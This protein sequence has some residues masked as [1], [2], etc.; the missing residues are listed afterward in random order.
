MNLR[1]D[2]KEI[3]IV[4]SN[5]TYEFQILVNDLIQ[6]GWILKSCSSQMMSHED[7]NFQTVYTAIM[8]KEKIMKFNDINYAFGVLTGFITALL[9]VA[10]IFKDTIFDFLK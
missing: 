1:T 4:E 6:K 10:I 9:M 8:V 5:K 7:Y 2:Q 3:Q